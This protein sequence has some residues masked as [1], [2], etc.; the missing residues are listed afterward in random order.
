MPYKDK[1]TQKE[2]NR[3]R[4]QKVRAGNTEAGNTELEQPPAVQPMMVTG[5]DGQPKVYDPLTDGL[6][7][8]HE[9]RGRWHVLQHN[10]GGV[11]WNYNGGGR[12]FYYHR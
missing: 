7:G 4:M 10:L 12:E 9:F 1:E 8:W 3:I 5:P 6:D 11:V 2:Y